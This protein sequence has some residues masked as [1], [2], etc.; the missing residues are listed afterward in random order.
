MK[1]QLFSN[2]EI[3]DFCQETAL[4]I[5]AGVSLGDG[6]ALLAEEG[7]DDRGATMRELG[8]RIDEGA[9][10]TEAMRESGRFPAY[11]IGLVDVGE[12]TGRLEETLNSL[13]RYY[14]DREMM[15]RQIRN[16]LMYPSILTILMWVVIVVLLSRVLPM[17][18]AA[19]EALGSNMTGMAGGLLLLGQWINRAMPVLCI[20]LALVVGGMILFAVSDRFKNKVLG[21]WNRSC[22]D[23]GV[24]RKINDSR[25][26]QALAMGMRSGLPTE[27]AVRQ[28]AALLE[29]V[30]EAYR[31]CEACVEKLTYGEDL[32]DILQEHQ[33]LPPSAC[34]LLSLGMKG[35]NGDTAMEEIARRLAE[36]ANQELERKVGRIEPAMVLTTSLLVGVILLSVMLPLMNIMSVIG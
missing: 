28:A 4:M 8:R 30:P 6:M 9:T 17:F 33:V 21:Q 16:A 26:A 3:A 2:L 20:L 36:E 32:A 7:S 1:Q 23:R 25:F 19:Y 31:R 35:G 5:H 24:S 13:S 15:D 12:S 11:V 34:R 18:E 29:E 27:E 14:E 22:G 10:L